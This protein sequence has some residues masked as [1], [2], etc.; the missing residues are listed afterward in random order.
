[1]KPRRFV[2]LLATGTVLSVAGLVQ[3]AFSGASLTS[4]S[5]R[6]STQVATA[7]DWSPPSVSASLIVQTSGGT[8]GNIGWVLRQGATFRV[9]AN[10]S[11]SISGV[12]TVTADVSAIASGQTAAPLIPASYTVAG[13]TYNYAT[14][15]LTADAVLA[16]GDR[17]WSLS[18]VDNAT[19]RIAVAHNATVDDTGPSTSMNDPGAYLR[20]TV[21]LGATASDGVAGL[22]A[23]KIRIAPTG[24]SNWTDVCTAIFMPLSCDLDTTQRTD[25]AYDLQAVATDNVGNT[26]TST[27]SAR[28]IDNGAPSIAR[29]VV[30]RTNSGAPASTT[31]WV[32]QGGTY[33]IYAQASDATSGL[34]SVT[35]NASNLTSGQTAASL[36][37]GSYTVAG[38]AYNYASAE[39]T[40]D[41]ALAAGAKTV[42][43]DATDNASNSTSANPSV[44]VDNTVPTT[45]MSDPGTYL[46]ATVAANAIAA[47]TGGS[48]LESLKIRVAP[49][50][51]NNWSDVCTVTSSP[52][53]CSLATA[54]YSDGA[55]DVQSLAI[56]GAGNAM[57]STVGSRTFDN[58][59]PAIARTVVVRTLGGG[60]PASS[61]GFVHQGGTYRVYAQA[62]DATSGLNTVTADASALTTGQ[63]AAT[64]TAGSYTVAGQTYDY[65][66]AE[67]TADATLAEGAKTVS[68]RA[69]DNSTNAGT[70]SPAVAVDN[71]APAA[72]MT[73]PGAFL[74]GSVTLGAT[75]SDSGAGLESLK[76]RVAPS[77]MSNWTEVCAVTA[78]P[79]SCTLASASHAD[80]GYDVQAL[81][82]DKAGNATTSTVGNRVIDNTGP[83][84]AGVVLVRTSGGTPASTTGFLHQGGTYRVYAQASDAT[85][86]VS[87]VTVNAS[88]LTS[89][90][91]AVPMTAGSYTVA[92]QSYNYAGAELTADAT[93]AEGAR[94]VSVSATDRANNTSS[95][96][97]SAQIDNT[98][99]NASMT[100]PGTWL[101]GTIALS[102][103]GS[104]AFAGLESLLIRFAPTGT[105]TWTT[106]CSGALSPLSCNINTTSYADGGY[107]F[108]SLAM[109]GAGNNAAS[110]VTNRK[111]DNTA[112]TAVTVATTN[113]TGGTQGKVEPGDSVTF[114]FSE[115]IAPATLLAG[116]DGTSTNVTVRF[117]GSNGG[118]S[119][120]VW[121]AANTTQLNFGGVVMGTNNY[122]GN[123][124][125]TFT[126]SSM[127]Q[128][129]ASVT[130]TL[131]TLAS[132]RAG[133]GGTTIMTWTPSAPQAPT[134]L[135]GNPQTS[136]TAASSSPAIKRF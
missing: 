62:S 127:V 100:D 122:A 51:T 91:T 29:T 125:P 83:A 9:Y 88:S 8:P 61:T 43:V 80:G 113:R 90:Q 120:T 27:L 48:A 78:S 31:G 45:T 103:T 92:G 37:S 25:G 136:A 93:L 14:P 79:A 36:S 75:G 33:R 3:L 117:T 112:P 116:W 106:I 58:T 20:G 102:A 23:L 44:A 32:R 35:A 60:V 53:S 109:D 55:Y 12:D 19:N 74:R 34:S 71:T 52:A 16:E 82:I 118:D 133:N 49:A 104:D 76:I 4:A 115:P 65:A 101:R 129:G 21:A 73:D 67:L 86:G 131:G 99:P 124:P 63:S 96:A 84:I 26:T 66:S 81:A 107:D 13:Q 85:S 41:S 40:A 57:T 68:V 97:P 128:S 6:H 28:A 50:G 38:Q 135:A 70:L 30:V 10:V 2:G 111:I 119:F 59:A 110:T 108:Q 39:L 15:E 54:S 77:G 121:D 22:S 105:T 130:I 7:I 98:A 123:P 11:D 5:P 72:L 42:W 132:G 47:D 1:M 69:V 89:G 64:M 18:A 56:D 46:K 134:D 126:A 95:A 24:T 94:V 114:T 17:Q 87:G